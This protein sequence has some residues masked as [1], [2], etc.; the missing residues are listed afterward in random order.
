MT[1][2]TSLFVL[3]IN[4]EHISHIFLVFLNFEQVNVFFTEFSSTSYSQITGQQEKGEVNSN[5]SLPLPPTSRT[6]RH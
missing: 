1:S 3:I 2:V 4:F 6:L 5:S